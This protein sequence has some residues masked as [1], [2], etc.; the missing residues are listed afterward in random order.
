MNDRIKQFELVKGKDYK[1][2][3][4]NG[5]NSQGGRLIDEYWLTRKIA[6]DLAMLQNNER[7]T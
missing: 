6:K 3:A 4:E 1:V 7:G 5:K 2:F